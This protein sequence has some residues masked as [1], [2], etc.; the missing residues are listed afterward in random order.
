MK[1]LD[2]Y[3]F[4]NINKRNTLL[5]FIKNKAD[6]EEINKL[7]NTYIKIH[8]GDDS[9]FN[10]INKWIE[11]KMINDNKHEN[12]FKKAVH[13]LC[14]KFSCYEE[15][16]EL[17]KKQLSDDTLYFS[18][19]FNRKDISINTFHE[20]YVKKGI[21][22]PIGFFKK[23]YE[24]EAPGEP[25]IGKGEFLLKLISKPINNK[26][27]GDC[28]INDV[29]IEVKNCMENEARLGNSSKAHTKAIFNFLNSISNIEIKPQTLSIRSNSKGDNKKNILNII[30]NIYSFDKDELIDKLKKSLIEGFYTD[31]NNKFAEKIND[32]KYNE[33]INKTIEELQKIKNVNDFKQ[34][35]KIFTILYIILYCSEENATYLC[36]IDK[37][38]IFNFIK[39]ENNV[40]NFNNLLTSKDF[41]FDMIR[42]SSSK[43]SITIRY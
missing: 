26:V 3:L 31:D 24:E 13:S 21:N 35:V 7:Y 42:Y 43:Y 39:V 18:I 2:I 8:G 16:S 40:E 30:N 15:I 10:L 6:D 41:P 19:D 25:V 11:G 22:I 12:A 28:V 17:A 34:F 14:D 5:S 29:G 4:E 9:A 1:H 36:A 20:Y 33:V 37:K 32:G 27:G 38:E 23:L